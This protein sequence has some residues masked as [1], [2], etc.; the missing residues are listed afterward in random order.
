ML[1]VNIMIHR[2]PDLKEL[3][4][5]T[6][7]KHNIY[8]AADPTPLDVENSAYAGGP[9]MRSPGSVHYISYYRR[10][11]CSC[12]PS[13]PLQQLFLHAGMNFVFMPYR[14]HSKPYE[15]HFQSTQ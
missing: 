11:T 12:F 5:F 2:F 8:F 9:T 7:L 4:R 6:S 1:D 14:P 15:A 10:A 13:Q 3:G